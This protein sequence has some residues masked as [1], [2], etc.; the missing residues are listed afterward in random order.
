VGVR[1]EL[2]GTE[3]IGRI[4][5]SSPTSGW[6]V[7]IYVAESAPATLAEW[8]QPVASRSDIAGSVDFGGLNVNGRDVL[9]WITR[10]GDDKSVQIKEVTLER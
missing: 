3:K 4:R 9:I 6:S 2:G 1:L 8:A 5:I 7:Q 10:L